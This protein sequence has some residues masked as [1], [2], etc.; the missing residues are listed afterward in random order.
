MTPTTFKD[1]LKIPGLSITKLNQL[2]TLSGMTVTKLDN[3]LKRPSMSVTKLDELLS[4][5][6][7]DVIKLEKLLV[8]MPLSEIDDFL[9]KV[10]STKFKELLNK[11]N[12]DV[13]RYY[14]SLFFKQYKGTTQDTIEH[15]LRN[16]GIRRGEIKGCHDAMLFFDELVIQGRGQIITSTPHPSHPGIVNHEYKLFVR[17]RTGA[18]IPPPTLKSGP[19]S[20]KTVLRDL[21]S[22]ADTWKALANEAADDAIRSKRFPRGGGRFEGRTASGLEIE[23]WYRGGPIE[24]FYPIW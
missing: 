2:L 16:D 15:L 18:I 11:F 20:I 24:T 10:G 7:H 1:L 12:P 8:D 5:V 4:L 9:L 6:D 19:P 17:D 22:D 3:L 21:A 13:L 14:G 23:G